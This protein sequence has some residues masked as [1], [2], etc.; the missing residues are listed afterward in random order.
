[1]VISNHLRPLSKNVLSTVGD[2]TFARMLLPNSVKLLAVNM[3]DDEV[4]L[5]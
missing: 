4:M 3:D 5:Q 1:M 2:D